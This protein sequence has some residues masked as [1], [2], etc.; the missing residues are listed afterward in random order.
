MTK[1]QKEQIIKEY[2]VTEGDTGSAQVQI[3]ILTFRINELNGHLKIHK[4][5]HHSG[6]GL[7]KMIGN[8]RN[9]QKYLKA[10]DLVAYNAL[11]A[12]LGLRK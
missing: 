9:L 10:K 12:K 6:R 11:I 1:I 8:R 4:K 5:D 3:A 2:A 7:L